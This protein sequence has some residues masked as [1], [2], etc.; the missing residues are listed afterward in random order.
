VAIVE[1]DNDA[2]LW[3]G[4]DLEAGTTDYTDSGRQEDLFASRSFTAETSPA[5]CFYTASAA[6]WS[7][8]GTAL[9]AAG[10]SSISAAGPTMTCICHIP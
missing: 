10:L 3:K 2:M 9:S 7:I 1:A 6:P 8:S 4:R 5:S